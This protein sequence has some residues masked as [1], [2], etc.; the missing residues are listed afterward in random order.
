[1]NKYELKN[2]TKKDESFQTCF[3]KLDDNISCYYYEA[4][5]N[6]YVNIINI[7]MVGHK[8]KKIEENNIYIFVK[9][10]DDINKLKNIIEYFNSEYDNL[11]FLYKGFNNSFYNQINDISKKLKIDYEIVD[12]NDN[13]NNIRTN[14]NSNNYIDYDINDNEL[15]KKE[16]N[17]EEIEKELIKDS[18]NY[19]GYNER[20]IDKNVK[21]IVS[22]RFNNKNNK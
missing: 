19:N 9:E 20:L 15:I 18:A 10:D 17:D 1:M 6:K 4:L 7:V 16:D 13:S 14:N 2:I 22:Y 12:S 11:K 3:L 21:N 8:I 5:N